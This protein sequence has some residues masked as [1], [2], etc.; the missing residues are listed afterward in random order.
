MKSPKEIRF[1]GALPK[2]PMGKVLKKNLRAL[3]E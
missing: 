1:V 2:S 3:L